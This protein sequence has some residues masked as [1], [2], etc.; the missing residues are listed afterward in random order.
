MEFF[1]KLYEWDICV[2][3]GYIKKEPDEFIDD[4]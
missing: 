4:V 1:D 3:T 2:E